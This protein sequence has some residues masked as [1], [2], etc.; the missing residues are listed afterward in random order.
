[1]GGGGNK[2]LR[3][4][5]KYTFSGEWLYCYGIQGHVSFMQHR[6]DSRHAPSEWDTSLQ[7]NGVSYWLGADL[8]S[9]LQQYI[10][11]RLWPN[12]CTVNLKFL[13]N[14][15]DHMSVYDHMS[16]TELSYNKSQTVNKGLCFRHLQTHLFFHR[17]CGILFQIP[18]KCVPQC[19]I[20]YA[21]RPRWINSCWWEF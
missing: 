11:F 1:M 7:Y 4:L 5:S 2:L 10:V 21:I 6:P 3:C 9:A 13:H 15:R 14:S 18:P 12:Q 17:I 8:E 20:I 16:Y 19:Q